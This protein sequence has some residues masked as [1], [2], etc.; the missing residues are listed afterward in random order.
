MSMGMSNRLVSQHL[1]DKMGYI[2]EPSC[3]SPSPNKP[4]LEAQYF[5]LLTIS[6]IEGSEEHLEIVLDGKALTQ[7][8]VSEDFE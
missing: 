8:H 3:V 7:F 4:T 2:V 1:S 6:E 5:Y